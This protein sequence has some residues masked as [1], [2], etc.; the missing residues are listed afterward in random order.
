[1]AEVKLAG[2]EDVMQ[3][4]Y[5][6]FGAAGSIGGGV[7]RHLL[8][9]GH[10]VIASVREHHQEETKEL[11]ASGAIVHDTNDVADERQL[12]GL[13]LLFFATALDGIVCAVGHCPPNGFPEAIKYPLSQLPLGK[14][15]SEINMHQVGVLNIFQCMLPTLVDGGCFLFISSAITRLKGQFPLFL[16]AHYPA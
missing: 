5:L 12:Y 16:Q 7:V 4:T 3:K 13:R 6:V 1:M 15:Q 11:M 14:Y 10:Q 9:A 8:A 2:E